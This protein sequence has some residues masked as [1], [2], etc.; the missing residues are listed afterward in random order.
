MLHAFRARNF[1]S[2]KDTVEVSFVLNQKAPDSLYIAQAPSGARLNKVMAVVG[3]NG[4][5]KTNLLKIPTYLRW[6][7]LYS[8]QMLEP[9]APLRFNPF[10]LQ[11]KQNSELGI[12]FE[13]NGQIYSYEIVL[14]EQSILDETLHLKGKRSRNLIHRTTD[15]VTK[16]TT[17]RSDW[18]IKSS[19]ITKILRPNSTIVSLLK[20]TEDKD[21]ESVVRYFNQFSSNVH[22]HNMYKLSDNDILAAA[23]YFY[24]RSDMKQEVDSMLANFDLGLRQVEIRKIIDDD[25]KEEFYLP[26]GAHQI[27]KKKIMLPFW[28][29]SSGTQSLFVLLSDILPV[30]NSGGIAIIDEF[31]SDLHPHMIPPVL[32]LFSNP[33]TNPNNA[34]LIFSCHSM[35]TLNYLNKYQIQLVEKNDMCESES[36]RLDSMTGV[37]SDDNIYAK[38]MSGAYGGVPNIR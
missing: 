2:F 6:L 23:E 31:E 9:D 24:Q 28:Q 3:P 13:I 1:Y 7:M 10:F 11:A 19:M 12:D 4:S 35:E 34:Q 26:Y 38:Y 20:Q 27:G 16:K 22:G 21:S 17:V 15:P 18:G 37:R 5:G 30:L 32:D 8:F 33:N 25:K 36:W 14:S 29:E